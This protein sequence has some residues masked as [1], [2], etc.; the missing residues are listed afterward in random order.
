MSD[1]MSVAHKG[2]IHFQFSDKYPGD[3]V[4]WRDARPPELGTPNRTTGRLRSCG[5]CGSMHP[6][7][8][9]AAI[10]A[11]ARGE[12]ADRKYG[13][14]HKAYFSEIPNPHRGLLE[15]RMSQSHTPP[16]EEIDAG[17]WLHLP[18]GSFS[19]S[20]GEPLFSWYEAGKPAAAMTW[21]K[22]YTVHL[23][24]ATPE[25][26]EVIERHLG[27]AFTFEANGRVSWLNFAPPP[28][29]MVAQ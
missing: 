2:S 10:K 29:G 9:A 16:Q 3:L 27:L 7:D 13:W 8:V 18:T 19:S 17:K 14:P 6:A 1:E 11:G 21:G 26:R 4:P 25:D 24:D 5:Y 23:Q 28:Q 15:S 20:T 12:W 22:F